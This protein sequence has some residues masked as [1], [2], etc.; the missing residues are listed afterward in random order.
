MKNRASALAVIFA[1]LL[2]GCILGIAGYHF[3]EKR[4]YGGSAVSSVGRIP[5][6]TGRLAEQLQLTKEQEKQLG[7]ILE[8]SRHQIE[9]GRNQWDLKLQEIRTKTN[10]R[11]ATILNDEQKQKFQTILSTAG[12]HGRSSDEQGHG[13]GHK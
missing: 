11:I 10:E 4:S 1:V 7:V 6:H 3:F 2:I 5:G 12:S 9:T 8:E 13:R